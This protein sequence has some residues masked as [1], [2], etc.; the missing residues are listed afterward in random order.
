MID[1]PAENLIR[2]LRDAPALR[3]GAATGPADAPATSTDGTVMAGHFSV[4]DTW[5][6]IDSVFEGRF[7]E[8]VAPGAFR[9]TFAEHRDTI[10]VQLDH[11]YDPIVGDA[12]LGPVDVLREDERGGYFEVPLLDTDYNRDRVVPQLAGRL[13]N[14]EA[15]GSLLGS[16]FRFRVVR[17]EWTEPAKAT[18]HNPDQLPE[19]TIREARVF[20]FGP[21]V[22]PAN[23][24]ATAAL[25][26]LTDHYLAKELTRRGVAERAARLLAAPVPHAAD[27]APADPAT[28]PT[29]AP[30]TPD[31]LMVAAARTQLISLAGRAAGSHR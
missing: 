5:Y 8:R 2:G 12:L 30:G 31:G 24:A 7:L 14:G 23:D 10:K 27:L 3:D 19:R 22:W 9:K 6:A 16:S 13:L 21:V 25:R 15:R 18:D 29:P 1:A 20:E 11:G 4:F 28:P 17:D 26:G